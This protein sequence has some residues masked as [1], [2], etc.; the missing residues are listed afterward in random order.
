MLDPRVY[1]FSDYVMSNLKAIKHLAMRKLNSYV[2]KYFDTAD[3]SSLSAIEDKR[4]GYCL[5]LYYIVENE[6][7]DSDLIKKVKRGK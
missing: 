2:Y 1:A 3:K 6:P 4:L 5:L 7:V